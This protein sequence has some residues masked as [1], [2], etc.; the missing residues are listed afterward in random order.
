[1]AQIMKIAFPIDGENI[2]SV[3]V[4]HF[5]RA[6]NFLVYDMASGSYK[7]YENPESAGKGTLPPNFLHQK[8]VEAV[9]CFGLGHRAVELLNELTIEMYKAIPGTV[10][11]NV[12]QF[13]KGY[14]VHF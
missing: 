11:E 3:V 5:G 9:A 7:V 10:E 2:N 1:M 12:E 6:K 13:K 4:E 14:L 8:D